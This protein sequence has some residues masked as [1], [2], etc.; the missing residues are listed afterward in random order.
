MKIAALWWKIYERTGIGIR[1][2]ATKFRCV[3]AKDSQRRRKK[4][5]HQQGIQLLFSI[6]F[7]AVETSSWCFDSF[8]VE[9]KIHCGG[10]VE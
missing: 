7:G 6:R 5:I 4:L 8:V 3:K 2:Q 1:M 10:V 9:I